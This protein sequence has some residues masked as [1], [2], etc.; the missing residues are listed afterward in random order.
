MCL[1]SWTRV[2][3]VTGAESK[4]KNIEVTTDGYV[5]DMREGREEEEEEKK[6][7]IAP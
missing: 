4:S 3:K 1:L 2:E 5:A 7:S 6:K